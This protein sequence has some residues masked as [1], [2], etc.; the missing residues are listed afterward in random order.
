MTQKKSDFT[1]EPK[2]QTSS[3]PIVNPDVLLETAA[4]LVK[5]LNNISDSIHKLEDGLRSLNANF[6]FKQHVWSGEN[7]ITKIAEERHLNVSAPFCI[8]GYYTKRCWYLS[9]EEDEESN[10]KKYR[11]FL[12]ESEQEYVYC[13]DTPEGGYWDAFFDENVILKKPL[14]QT[15]YSLKLRFSEHLQSFIDAFQIKLKTYLNKIQYNLSETDGI[16]F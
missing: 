14:M 3:E 1:A 13:H 12:I 15:N 16:S 2:N 9:W 10:A 6:P 11:L 8:N 7:S 4:E 5:K